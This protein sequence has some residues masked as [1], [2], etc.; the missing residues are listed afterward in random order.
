MARPY[1]MS[2][3]RFRHGE[4]L[5]WM[6]PEAGDAFWADFWSQRVQAAV[7]ERLA[8]EG[9]GSGFVA[10][11]LR[12][13]LRPDGLYLEAG[14]GSGGWV[15]RL[16]GA[17]HRVEGVE[18]AADLV[19]MV[20]AEAPDLPVVQGDVRDL[21]CE[22]GTYDGYLSFGVVEHDEE[23]PERFLSEAHRVIK[24]GGFAVITVPHFGFTRRRIHRR[25]QPMTPEAGE[26]FFQYAFTQ[27]EF[28]DL[29]RAA[30][31]TIDAVRTMHFDRMLHEEWWWYACHIDRRWM[32]P[33]RRS[34][35]RL[36]SR[37][38]GHMLAVVATR[39]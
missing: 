3:R 1:W 26:A 32:K 4:R 13:R 20:N 19:A 31:F 39:P 6:A 10:D 11:S 29:I 7:Y 33:I 24:P 2:H 37:F 38:D 27:K 14:C 12:R 25:S 9:L 23:G 22:E 8:T 35:D 5:V 16:K 36:L 15:A 34:L 28:V 30:G 21:P 17:G 18:S